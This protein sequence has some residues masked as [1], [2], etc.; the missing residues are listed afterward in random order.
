MV[1]YSLPSFEITC[2]YSRIGN[3]TAQTEWIKI[4]KVAIDLGLG[5]YTSRIINRGDQWGIY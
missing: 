5:I 4:L 2:I 1:A 3:T